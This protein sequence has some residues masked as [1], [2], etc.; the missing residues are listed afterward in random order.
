MY[1]LREES[2]LVTYATIVS[3]FFSLRSSR[4]L[5]RFLTLELIE[6][7]VPVARHLLQSL[8]I[9][10][11]NCHHQRLTRTKNGVY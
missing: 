9:Y 4:A 1:S 6:V 10:R 8:E 3:Q 5:D 11:A 7:E 2:K